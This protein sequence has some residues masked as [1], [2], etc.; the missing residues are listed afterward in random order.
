MRN[1]I[2]M[3]SLMNL[4]IGIIAMLFQ[5]RIQKSCLVMDYNASLNLT[6]PVDKWPTTSINN[7]KFFTWQ[8][9]GQFKIQYTKN[10]KKYKSYSITEKFIHT[11]HH[12]AIVVH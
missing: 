9:N 10:N 8:D 2:Y 4:E 3:D 6:N 7:T 5:H 11:I 1:T 12:T